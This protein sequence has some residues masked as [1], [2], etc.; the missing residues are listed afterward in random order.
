[1]TL[2][3]RTAEEMAAVAERLSA[4]LRA[5][6]EAR[7][8]AEL[9]AAR[10]EVAVIACG[11][12]RPR[13]ARRRPSSGWK[14]SAARRASGSPALED[15]LERLRLADSELARARREPRGS[16]R[17][18]APSARSRAGSMSATGRSRRATSASPARERE[19][20]SG[21]A[22]GGAGGQAADAIAR[23]VRADARGGGAAPRAARGSGD[24]RRAGRGARG[25]R[26]GARR[27]P[28]GGGGARRRAHRAQGVGVRTGGAGRRAGGRPAGGRGAGPT[29]AAEASA[30]RKTAKDLEEADRTRRSRLAE[31]EGKLLRLEHERSSAGQGG[32]RRP[33][34]SAV[35]NASCR[36]P[37]GADELRRQ[38]ADRSAAWEQND[39]AASRHRAA[40][41]RSRGGKW[42]R[43]ADCAGGDRART[44]AEETASRLDNTLGNYRQRAGRLRDELQGI[45]RRLEALSSAEIA[46]YL[47][48]LG[49]DLAELR[50]ISTAATPGAHPPRDRRP[51]V[52]VAIVGLGSIGREV[53]KA[54]LA[55]PGL[56]LLSVADPAHVGRDAGEVAG[57]GPCGVTVVG[58]PPRRPG[59]GADVALVLTGSGVAD[60]MP[61]V[62]AAAARGSTSSPPARTW[63]TPTSAR[64]T[65]RARLTPALAPAE[66]RCWGPASIPASSWTG[67]R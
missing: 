29:A 16:R 18:R 22:A 7:D 23:A 10:D 32:R 20:G 38:L 58:M 15:A 45:R 33:G 8:S 14:R 28:R 54:V 12:P 11:W 31:L 40:G 63:P 44:R 39:G 27:V 53:L 55:R 41:R 49:E 42:P 57:I 46:G 62:E 67:C 51:V 13:R 26:A 1:M 34:A 35:W 65:W 3:R 17:R 25:A 24:L 19:A 6:A 37:H 2:T 9:L 64:P 56:S 21:L 50:E 60:V 5:D 52:R 36:R 66:S 47:E 30:L 43:R 48:E 59:G 61:I 4:G